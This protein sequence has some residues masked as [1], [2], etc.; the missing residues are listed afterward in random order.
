MRGV[1][2]ILMCVF[3]MLMIVALNVASARHDK[4]VAVGTHHVDIRAVEARQH[5]RGYDLVDRPEHRLT[6][7]ELEHAIES[8]EQLVELMCAE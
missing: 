7:A 5:W 8:A 4:D 6:A 3:V 2:V 1:L